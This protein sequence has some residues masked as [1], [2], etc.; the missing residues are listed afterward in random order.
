MKL[1]HRVSFL[2][3]YSVLLKEIRRYLMGFA[4]LIDSAK[5]DLAT[6]F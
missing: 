3:Y 4:E 2:C 5:L 1:Y 6:I